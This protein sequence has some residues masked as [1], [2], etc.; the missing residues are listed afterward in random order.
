[1]GTVTDNDLKEVKELISQLSDRMNDRF[2][3]LRLNQEK[4]QTRLEDWKPAIDKIADLS[5]KVGE[6]KEQ[7]KIRTNCYHCLISSVLSGTITSLIWFFKDK[8]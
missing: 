5:E 1:M 8:I 7:R 3:E 2:N 6:S 4:I